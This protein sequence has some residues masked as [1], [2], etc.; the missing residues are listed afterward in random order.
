MLQRRRAEGERDLGLARGTNFENPDVTQVSIGTTVT[1]AIESDGEEI[2]QHPRRPGIAYPNSALSPTR[3]PSDR[4]CWARRWAKPS[5]SRPN[6]ATKK[7]A[8]KDIKPF[9]DLNALREK[10]TI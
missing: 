3:P 8:I 7:A 10:S 9:T 1:L 6:S 4:P 5:A 2:S